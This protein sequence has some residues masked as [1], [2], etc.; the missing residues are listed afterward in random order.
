VTYTGYATGTT[1]GASAAAGFCGGGAAPEA[2]AWIDVPSQL[3]TLSINTYGT[4]WPDVLYVQRAC[5]DSSMELGCAPS[6]GTPAL[7]E[8]S[9]VAPGGYFIGVD[10]MSAADMGTYYL[11]VFGI[12]AGGQPCTPGD[13]VFRCDSSLN[14]A[15]A[16]PIPGG[17]TVCVAGL[18][19]DGYDNDGDAITDWPNDPGCDDVLDN[20]ETDPVMTPECYDG[21]DNDADALTDFPADP[22]CED[23][24]DDLELDQCLP[25]LLVNNLPASGNVL[26]T[27]SGTSYLMASC[28]TSFSGSGPEAAWLLQVPAIANVTASTANPGTSFNTTLSL[29]DVC[30]DPS[31]ELACAS[32]ASLGQ[33]INATSLLPGSYF[34]LVDGRDLAAGSYELSVTGTILAGQPCDP[35]WLR[36][37]C[38]ATTACEVNPASPTGM[39]CT[40]ADCADGVDNDGDLVAD[41]PGDPG[42]MTPSD[43]TEANPSPLPQCAD[44]A[45]NDAD[46]LIDWPADTGCT[47][48]SDN[49]ETC[50]VFAGPDS[51]GYVGCEEFP[52]TTPCED[53]SASGTLVSPLSDDTSASVPLPF[54][55]NFYGVSETTASLISNGKIGFPGTTTY[56]NTCTIETYTIA[57]WWDDL[58]PPSG[59]TL[60]YQTFGT[61][62]NRH[63]V[64]QW[65]LPHIT[66]TWPNV[67]DV[68]AVLYEGTN[69]ILVCYVD[70]NLGTATL[71]F[72]ASATVGIEGASGAASLSYSC[73]TPSLSDG[74]TLRYL[75]P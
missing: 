69:D 65:N 12:I 33:T 2:F 5:G 53:I 41:Y 16:E 59:G 19:S 38:E 57:A 36:F 50:A 23:T 11:H 34:I 29:R 31:T 24:A 60:K 54:T 43:P 74:L 75:H 20:D 1:S 52:A 48:A 51:Y 9:N 30:D 17:G 68:R 10:G 14:F 26:G 40:L 18:C 42:C 67:I 72:G 70:T 58:Y 62:P 45:D 37:S 35:S 66:G 27:T 22:G 7:L 4:V 28:D 64:V 55:F 39:S 8:L 61:A 21:A 73:N 56:S 49:D 46:A 25:G 47:A 15:C 13:T 44:G 71:D 32:A 63:F 6:A 3:T